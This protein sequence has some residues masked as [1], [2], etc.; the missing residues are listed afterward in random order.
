MLRKV[1]VENG[2]IQGY[3]SG[4]PRIT[5]FKGVPYAAPPVGSLRWKAPQPHAPWEG[6]YRAD[7]FPPM[8]WHKQPG[9]DWTGFYTKEL[10]PTA[11]EY[12]MSEDC[13][14]LNIWTPAQS[15][16]EKLP[17]FYYIHGGGFSAGYS[18]E[19]EFDG[20]R[21]AKKGVIFVT[22]GYRLGVMGFFAHRDLDREAPGA[23]QGNFGLQ[24]QL[25]GI[26]WV[27]RNIAAFGGDPEKITIGGQ[28]AGGM[29]V[30]CL[31]TSPMAKGKFQGAIMMSCGGIS[32][33]GTGV[34]MDRS[35]ETAQGEGE[36]LL[37]L[38]GCKTVEEARRVD[39]AVLTAT[40]LSMRP[41]SGALMMWIPTI[42]RVFLP[43]N[44]RDAFLA[45]HTHAVPCMIGG[46]WGESRPNPARQPELA[47]AEAFRK[48]IKAAYGAQAEAFLALANVNDDAELAELAASEEAFSSSVASRAFAQRQ[49]YDGKTTYVYLFHHDIPGDDRGS[50]HGS[51]MWFTFDSLARCWRPFTGKHYDLARQVCSYWTNFVK[52]GDPNGLDSIGEALPRWRAYSKEDPFVICFKDQPEEFTPPE[53]ALMKLAKKRCLEEI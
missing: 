7:R 8:S 39:P 38:L 11:A 47:S 46:C 50:Y 10:N 41:A 36:T 40:A 42:D 30:Q 35:L 45:G 22:V 49:G 16:E 25:A 43:E 51:D 34:A 15:T 18:Y 4:D 5:V 6:V 14:Y 17:V 3:A 2:E 19:M 37:N 21:V 26:E 23:P 33:P 27:R 29:S 53:S 48:H 52:N 32:A 13:L 12:E 1:K 9:L 28:S 24:D 31:L 20:E 44:I